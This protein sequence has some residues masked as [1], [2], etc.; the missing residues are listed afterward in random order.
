MEWISVDD[1]FP[2]HEE[3]VLLASVTGC[4]LIGFYCDQSETMND[5]EGD[6]LDNGD[7]THWMPLPPPPSE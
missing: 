5:F 4:V 6:E 2:V 3:N 7:I 1:R